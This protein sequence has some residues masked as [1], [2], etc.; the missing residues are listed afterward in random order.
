MGGARPGP[1][2]EVEWTAQR[3]VAAAVLDRLE[4][5]VVLLRR[6]GVAVHI[7]A[8]IDATHALAS[9]DL[10]RRQE[11]VVALRATLVKR[12][13]DLPAF[14]SLVGRVFPTGATRPIADDAVGTESAA[15]EALNEAVRRA[16]A[17]GDRAQLRRLAERAV[18]EHAGLE[19]GAGERYHLQRVLRQLNLSALLQAALQTRRGGERGGP[20]DELLARHDLA[21]LADELRQLLEQ[22]IREGLVD[23]RRQAPLPVRLEDLDLLGASTTELRDL[24]HAV[25]PLARKLASRLGQN[26]RRHARRGRLDTRRTIRT[27]LGMGGVPFEPRLRHRAPHRPALWLL[28]DVSGSVAEFSR[29]TLSLV[30]AVHTELPR[31]RSFTF[32]DRIDEVTDLLSR[33]ANDV[34]PFLLL[35]R[36]TARRGRNQSDYGMVF[37]DFWARHGHELA[38][39][40][41]VLVTG[42]GRSHGRDP[43]L[44]DLEAIAS[45]VRHLFW[46][47]PDPRRSWDEGDAA[48]AFYQP[49]CEAVYEVR[50]L[51]QLTAAVEAVADR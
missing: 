45:R 38:P 11:V 2:T 37:A 14:D 21:D 44:G 19:H 34:D 29:F 25:A 9:I 4:T 39:T 43:G 16:L 15:E 17:D 22:L 50:N 48:M 40:A 36:A 12:A 51:A 26:R 20:L 47:D 49:L 23:Q 18:D 7:S 1:E 6:A 3:T 31:T 41:T 32:V 10:E 5:L 24:R 33:A 30:Q 35:T 8:V 13:E 28:C 46:F 27:S 42:D